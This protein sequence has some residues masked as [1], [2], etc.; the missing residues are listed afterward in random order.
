MPVSQRDLQRMAGARKPIPHMIQFMGGW[1]QITPPLSLASGFLRATQNYEADVIGGYSRIVGYE[2]SDGR[3]S[4]SDA[5]YAV[6]GIVLTGAIAAGTTVTG[7]TSAATGMVI[8]IPGATS[9]VVSK[10]TGTFVA[11]EVLNVAAS[12]QATTTTAAITGG[13]ST[14]I[15]NAQYLNLAADLYRMDIAKPPGSGGILGIVRYNDV[16][17]VWR[18]A[19]NGLTANIWK[20]TGSG[21]SQVTLYN[22][23][24]FTSGGATQPAE[25]DTLTQGGVTA[26]IKRVVL[27]SGTWAGSGAAGRLIVTN[28]AGGNFAAGAATDG[29]ITVTLS[30]VQT[31]IT[32][33]PGGRYEIK[34]E[35]FGG[36]VATKRIYGCDGVNRGFEFDGTVLAPITTGMTID[37]P[38]HVCVHKLHLFYSF[39]ASVQFSGPG[40]PYVW[41]VV[42]G[43]AGEI[44]MGENVNCFMVQPSS[45]AVGALAIFTTNKTNILYGTGASDFVL[46]PYR[47]QLGAYPYTSQDTGQTMFLDG[48]GVTTLQTVQAFG[49][50]TH[51]AITARI[52]TWLNNQR[53]KAVESCVV[54]DK[55]Q[56]RLFFSDGYALFVTFAVSARGKVFYMM[57]VLF[58]DPITCAYASTDSD[59]TETIFFGSANGMVYQM[60]RGTSFDG[61]DIDHYLVLA[62]DFL[63]SPRTIKNFKDCA[64]EVSGSGYAEF[65]FSYELGYAS[66]DIGQPNAQSAATN[67]LPGAWDAGGAVWDQGAWDG[68]T[69]MPSAFNMGGEAENV[70][71]II[72]GS[73]DYQSPIKFSGGIVHYIPR[74]ELRSA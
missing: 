53:T 66:S 52:K 44:G 68:Q 20:Q 6:I 49:N 47:D 14:A 1:D 4:P 63:K 35:N 56:Y 54:R 29:G 34:V 33:L 12:P 30:G 3:P 18:N 40:T 23:V 25:G 13:A 60:E 8:A 69:L 71:L 62:W 28:P 67:F 42:V 43:T 58:P 22:E 31:A 45:S 55:S 36:G 5:S 37:A 11:A 16:N 2:R 59:G 10:V 50:F 64:L 26:T 51:N 57:P 74:R 9:I 24:R 19:V 7:A 70:S 48:Q 32:L 17:Y 72:R 27:T 73:S 61:A 21:W 65:S 39:G 38:N 46:L 15:L 41:S